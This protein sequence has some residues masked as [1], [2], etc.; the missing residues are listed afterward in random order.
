VSD[1]GRQTAFDWANGHRGHWA[2]L[3]DGAGRTVTL[4]DYPQ[5]LL[6]MLRAGVLTGQAKQDAEGILTGE[7]AQDSVAKVP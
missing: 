7:S 3:K 1:K 6:S 5:S 2:V 4:T